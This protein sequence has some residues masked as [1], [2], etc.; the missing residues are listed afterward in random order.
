MQV[1]RV[2][3]KL[4][5]LGIEQDLRIMVARDVV[6]LWGQLLQRLDIPLHAF[7][8]DLVCCRVGFL[9]DDIVAVSLVSTHQHDIKMTRFKSL[10]ELLKHRPLLMLIANKQYPQSRLMLSL[11]TL[12][13]WFR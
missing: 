10:D 2:I 4:R 5:G 3:A 9:A 7:Q 1:D 6:H 13:G 8:S 11:N 12:F